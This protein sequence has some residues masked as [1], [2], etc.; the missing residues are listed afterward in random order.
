M[1]NSATAPYPRDDVTAGIL[2]G[3]RATR[4]GGIDKGLVPLAGRSMVEWV[5]AALRPQAARVLLNANRN[6]EEYGRLGSTVV[7]DHTQGF[8]GPLSGMASM[9]AQAQGAWL[10][11]APCDSPLVSAD[12]GPRLWRAAE[13]EGADIAVAHSGERLQPVFALLRC[14][15][16]PAL[17]AYLDAGER[18]IDRWYRQQRMVEVDFS[19]CADMFVNVNTLEERDALALKLPQ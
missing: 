18:K 8:L 6:A 19:D 7:A 13:R 15:L 16:R 3:G 17:E 2:A 12:Y 5:I 14:A 11:T 10:L 4:M 1:T 9:M